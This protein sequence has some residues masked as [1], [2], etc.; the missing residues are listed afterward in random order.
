M[1]LTLDSQYPIK[2]T[3]VYTNPEN[4]A[5]VIPEPFGDLTENSGDKGILPCPCI[6][7]INYVYALS[8]QEILSVANGNTFRFW[9]NASTEI[10]SYTIHT[11]RDYESQGVIATV[12]FSQLYQG[13]SCQMSGGIVDD[14]GGLLTN[15]VKVFNRIVG[16]VSAM[17]ATSYNKASVLA[18]ELGYTCA[19][20]I[21]SEYQ[22]KV[23]LNN[24]A[25]SFLMDWYTDQDGLIHI[26]LD[27]SRVVGLSPA[28]FLVERDTTKVLAESYAE[29]IRNQIPIYYAPTYAQRDRRFREG[30]NVNYLAYNDGTS[31][32][33]INSIRR[34][35]LRDYPPL[36]FDWTRNDA[37]IATIQARLAEKFSS[38]TWQYYWEEFSKQA[39]AAQEGDWGVFSWRHRFD[40]NGDRLEDKYIQLLSK[41]MPLIGEGLAFEFRETSQE[42]YNQ[43][44]LWNGS[45]LVLGSGEWW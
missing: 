13:V 15:P 42:Y 32:R 40:K 28:F 31:T 19:G 23:W 39:V 25:S 29:N 7:T 27:S 37:T 26:R 12:T 21:T 41:S 34:Y 36:E 38:R 17:D 30:V 3:H 8:G 20:A 5:D 6:D 9:D 35:G 18:D 14:T 45:D 2:K 43:V 11:A 16:G 10:T 44:N 22:Y 33:D 24:L 4:Q 1:S